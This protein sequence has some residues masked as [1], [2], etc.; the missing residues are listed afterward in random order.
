MQLIANARV[1]RDLGIDAK[2][3][4]KARRAYDKFTT[5]FFATNQGM[6]RG[7]E[8]SIPTLVRTW[9]YSLEGMVAKFS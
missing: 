3:K 5:N 4:L 2:L 9:C 1:N 7:V 8:I 6:K